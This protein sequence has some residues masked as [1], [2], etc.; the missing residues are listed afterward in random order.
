MASKKLS[1]DVLDP[2][3]RPTLTLDEAAVICGI[4]KS[5]AYKLAQTDEFPVPLAKVGANWRV[6]TRRLLETLAII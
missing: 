4:S 5:Q 2:V 6:P 3:A 1:G